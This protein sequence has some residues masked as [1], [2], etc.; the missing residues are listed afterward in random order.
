MEGNIGFFH[1]VGIT[2]GKI[3]TGLQESIT[4]D[5]AGTVLK[6][7]YWLNG[8]IRVWGSCL[9]ANFL[10]GE[11]GS[12]GMGSEDFG[13]DLE[14]VGIEGTGVVVKAGNKWRFCFLD[15]AIATSTR[16]LPPIT[17]NPSHSWI[18]TIL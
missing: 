11:D 12:L 3:A 4:T 16:A 8:A 17:H 10:G 14:V 9:G 1:A 6:A 2:E 13:G 18:S 15:K 5:E 7:G